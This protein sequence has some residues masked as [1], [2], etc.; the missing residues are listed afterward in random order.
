MHRIGQKGSVLVQHLIF[1]N[2]VDARMAH[3]IIAKQEVI[4]KALDRAIAPVAVEPIVQR[5]SSPETQKT[6]VAAAQ[7]AADQS[8]HAARALALLPVDE[9]IPF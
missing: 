2:S 7:A 5:E 9:E 6:D 8:A 4:E 1:D 3:T